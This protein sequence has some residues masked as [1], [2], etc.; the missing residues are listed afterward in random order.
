MPSNAPSNVLFGHDIQG[1]QSERL[2]MADADRGIPFFDTTLNQWFVFDGTRWQPMG[3]LQFIYDPGGHIKPVADSGAIGTV[4]SGIQLPQSAIIL[5]GIIEI[6]HAFVGAGASLAI[7]ANS[8]GDMLATTPV[9]NLTAGLTNVIPQ[10]LAA[11]AVKMLAATD[12]KF[13]VS[14]APFTDGTLRG[15]LRWVQGD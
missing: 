4:D 7:Q 2:A 11:S 1:P 14:G 3:M 10:G 12:I 13:V 8:A 15:F 6:S 5:D 9:A